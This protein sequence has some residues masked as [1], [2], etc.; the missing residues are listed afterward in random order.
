MEVVDVSHGQPEY[1][2]VK[3]AKLAVTMAENSRWVGASGVLEFRTKPEQF[4][5]LKKGVITAEGGRANLMCFQNNVKR[6]G[7]TAIPFSGQTM[8]FYG[9][10]ATIV[11]IQ[12]FP[13]G[14]SP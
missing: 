4:F 13:I 9:C 5:L 3:G 12:I 11:W 10:Q 6:S 2:E 8:V 1:T 14:S 7:P